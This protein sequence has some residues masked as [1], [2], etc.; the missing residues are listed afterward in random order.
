MASGLL[1]EHDSDWLNRRCLRAGKQG[2]RAS[3]ESNFWI[4]FVCKCALN[5]LLSDCNYL[6]SFVLKQFK[7]LS[8]FSLSG[9]QLVCALL[10]ILLLHSG[11][12]Q[13]ATS[14][15]VFQSLEV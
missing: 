15:L 8:A 14:L 3:L 12:T 9:K 7:N 4:F 6:D 5:V 2:S 13:N 10:T 11:Q 1:P